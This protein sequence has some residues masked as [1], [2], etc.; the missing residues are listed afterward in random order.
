GNVGA[1][2][3]LIRNDQ[4]TDVSSMGIGLD[5][6]LIRRDIW[7][8]LDVGVKLQD[9]T[10]TYI[11]WSTGK[12]EFIYPALK[13]GLGYPLRLEDMNST[14]LLAVDGDFRFENMKGVS[15]FWIGRASADFHFGAELLIRDMVALRGGY[16]M[17]R[18]T[19]GAGFLL[20]DFGPW[21]ISLGI[22]YALL[23]HD[24]LDNTHRV[25]LMISH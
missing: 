16:D 13:I 12:R 11:T 9:V 4:V 1:S 8:D 3:K 10:G 24:E 25:S 14:L 19:A 21:N 17:G 22:D 6:G 5:V 23:I 20:D 2:L 15:Q 18:P 7:K